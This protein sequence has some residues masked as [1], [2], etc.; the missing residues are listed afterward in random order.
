MSP[1]WILLDLRTME[2]AVITG[3]MRC[4]QLQSNHHHQQTNTHLFA[5]QMP[6]LSPNQQCQLTA[7]KYKTSLLFLRIDTVGWATKKASGL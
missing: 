1:F 5:G 4:A 2:V 6:F 3:A 7:K